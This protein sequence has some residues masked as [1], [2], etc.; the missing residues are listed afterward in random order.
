MK[1][2]QPLGKCKK[3]PGYQY[4]RRP[5]RTKAYPKGCP[6]CWELWNLATQV[7]LSAATGSEPVESKPMNLNPSGKNQYDKDVHEYARH[8]LTKGH[9]L[10]DRL[11]TMADGLEPGASAKD[12]LSA[13][14][15]LYKMMKDDQQED[16]PQDIRVVVLNLKDTTFEEYRDGSA[17]TP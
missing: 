9:Y 16:K 14:Q 5:Q 11:K 3:H 10:V 12:V 17:N 15:L 2:K 7:E 1:K 6:R 13:I 8:K 4:K